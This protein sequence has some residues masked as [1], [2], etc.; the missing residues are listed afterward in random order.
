MLDM[1][2]YG[3]YRVDGCV[4]VLVDVVDGPTPG[5]IVIGWSVRSTAGSYHMTPATLRPGVEP[6]L[7]QLW[8]TDFAHGSQLVAS[9]QT[10]AYGK[11]AISPVDADMVLRSMLNA[12][13][14]RSI[15]P[16]R[17]ERS[18]KIWHEFGGGAGAPESHFGYEP[19]RTSGLAAYAKERT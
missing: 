2:D 1:T 14:I 17:P 4:L 12:G 13:W 15:G 7:C 11:Y 19:I 18:Q 6:W 8:L 9:M 16:A 5:K 10:A 3:L